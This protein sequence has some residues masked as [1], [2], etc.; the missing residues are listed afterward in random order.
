[1]IIHCAELPE[2]PQEGRP[3]VLKRVINAEEH[4]ANLSLTWVRIWGHHER[5][6]NAVCD[7]AYYVI[8]GAGR[9]QVGDGAAIEP[10]SAGDAVFIPAGTPYEFEGRMTYLVAN[11]PAF[12]AGSD[13]VLPAAFPA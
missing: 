2:M 1:M 10:V 3:L 11:G 4:T 8:A 5:V 9:F 7:R 13:Q 6:V 12:I